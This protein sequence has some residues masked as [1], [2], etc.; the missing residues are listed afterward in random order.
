MTVK[1]NVKKKVI[2]K[3]SGDKVGEKPVDK[4]VPEEVSTPVPAKPEKS[5]DGALENW[6]KDDGEMASLEDWLDEDKTDAEITKAP[7][8]IEKPDDTVEPTREEPEKQDMV[9][10]RKEIMEDTSK[11]NPLVEEESQL[12]ISKKLLMIG[13]I[14]CAVGLIGMAG[15]RAGIIQSLLGDPNPYPG[16]GYVEP[17]GHIVSVI[18]IVLGLL[19]IFVWGIRNNPVYYELEKQ[20]EEGFDFE[21]ETEEKETPVPTPALPQLSGPVK[22]DVKAPEKAPVAIAKPAPAKTRKPE[23]VVEVT[24]TAKDGPEDERLSK[25]KRLLANA[26]ILPDDRER[27]SLLIPSGISAKDFQN[28]VKNAVKKKKKIEEKALSSDDK[29]TLLEEELAA[30]LAELEDELT[31]YE[32]EYEDDLEE[33]ILKEIEDLE[34][35]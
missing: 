2:K 19:T 33:K 25:C 8:Q 20:K 7:E 10:L 17:T 32:D 11:N 6:L 24:K 9:E 29:A 34:D 35:L 21:D 12:M 13:F 4:K 16:I 28:E 23:A 30:E 1:Q 18:P 27:L 26:K 15:L 14:L 22:E 31:D 3:S 5:A